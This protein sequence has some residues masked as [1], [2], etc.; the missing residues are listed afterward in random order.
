MLAGW[1]PRLRER[2]RR[3]AAAIV[4]HAGWFFSGELA[5]QVLARFSPAVDTVAVVGGHLA[6]GGGILAAPEAG[7]ETPL[8]TVKRDKELY[9]ELAAEIAL[10]EDRNADNTVEV[11][12]P[13]IRYLY[14]SASILWLRA[15]PDE[16]A[17]ELGSCLARIAD[18]TGR[19]LAVAGSTDLTHYG[20]RYGFTPYGEGAGIPGRVEEEHDRPFL[21]ALLD[22]RLHEA[23]G[24]AAEK[25][26][27][28]SAGA[29]VCA[30][31]FAQER[32]AER[33]T[34]LGYRSSAELY[35]EDSFVGYGALYFE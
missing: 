13:M 1:M 19:N 7:Y 9:E 29:A 5:L 14:P 30:V 15:A 16:S 35:P 28:C 31:R 18:K 21:Q 22:N 23:L 27:A 2:E 20:P 25:R 32:G 3:A 34:L 17:L 12:L 8:G 6:P 24:L 4:P 33:G 10:K 26:S 11:E